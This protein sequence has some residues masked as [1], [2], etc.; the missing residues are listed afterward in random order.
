VEPTPELSQRFPEPGT[1]II[2][3]SRKY[4]K[5][6]TLE[7][8]KQ[9]GR[10]LIFKFSQVDSIESALSLVA[11]SLYS[12]VPALGDRVGDESLVLGFSVHD[13]RGE[14]WGVV[15]DIT[16]HG[17]SVTLEVVHEDRVILVPYH[18]L[19][20]LRMSTEEKLLVIDPPGG[21]KDLNR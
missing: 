8:V 2:L 10:R 6:L 5:S 11:Y 19:L 17:L 13:S 18:P 20:V 1:L 15:R 21:L 9:V 3:K 14:C 4:Q 12:E 7:Y 16:R